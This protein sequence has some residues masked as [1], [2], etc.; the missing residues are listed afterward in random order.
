MD[1]VVLATIRKTFDKPKAGVSPRAERCGVLVGTYD[2]HTYIVNGFYEVKNSAKT[3][4]K[5][6]VIMGKDVRA[7]AKRRGIPVES[8]IGSIHTHPGK[9]ADT[10]PS[11]EDVMEQPDD[12][13]GAV[14]HPNSATI[15][16]YNYKFGFIAREALD[17]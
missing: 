12:T 14:Y 16:Y 4:T 3:P 13:L 5:D 8:V 15:T 10:D 9:K 17:G 7:A 6:F 2:G 1:P 11:V